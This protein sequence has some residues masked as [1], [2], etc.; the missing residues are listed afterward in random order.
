MA[1][2]RRG[3]HLSANLRTGAGL[4]S[5]GG[6]VSPR[7][8]STLHLVEL[9]VGAATAA[10]LES[11]VQRAIEV[12][13]DRTAE[14]GA[15][16]ASMHLVKGEARTIELVAARNLDE[17]VRRR[18]ARFSFDSES[19][20]AG[21]VRSGR[22]IWFERPE[23]VTPEFDIVR[24][25][26]EETEQGAVMSLPMHA[27]DGTL[28]AVLTIAL[29]EPHAFSPEEFAALQAIARAYGLALDAAQTR[30]SQHRELDRLEKL[31]EATLA[32]FGA[33]DLHV[34][35]QRIVE[36][37]RRVSGARFAALGIL[38]EDD[39][40][41]PFYPYVFS[42]DGENTWPLKKAVRPLPV[43]RAAQGAVCA[44]DLT[45]DDGA[46]SPPISVKNFLGSPVR[47]GERR[48]G[49]LYLVD[50]LGGTFSEDDATA[51]NLLAQHA[52]IA[53]EHARSREALVQAMR[54]KEQSEA[55]LRESEA[56]YRRL[57]ENAPDVVF[58]LELT[59][60]PH[61][62]FLSPAIEE[63][64]GQPP[65]VFYKDP[66]AL[67]R[68]VHPSDRA[69][70]DLMITAPERHGHG[71]ILRWIHRDGHLVWVEARF[72]ALRDESGRLLS[73][74]GI[75]RDVS[76]AKRAE[77]EVEILL[78][79]VRAKRAWLQTVIDR[80]PVGIVLL[81]DPEGR[82]ILVNREAQQLFGREIKPDGGVEQ[83]Q[84]Q[85]R[86]PEGRPIPTEEAL[87][88]RALHGEAATQEE[89]LALRPDGSEIP[90]LVSAT[91]IRDPEGQ[92]EGAVVIYRDISTLKELERMREEWTSI[93]AHDLRQP[94]N[95]I[96]LQASALVR[97]AKDPNVKARA[98][99]IL[100]S[101]RQL[102]RLISDLLEFSR[103][104]S[105]NLSIVHHPVDLAELARQVG[106][107]AL[108]AIPDRHFELVVE[109]DL[110]DVPCD[111]GRIEQVLTNLISNAVKYGY[112]NTPIRVV[113]DRESDRVV[114]SV[115]N[116]GQ[117][118][119]PE[120]LPRLFSR[121]H[122]AE[123]ARKSRIGGIGLGLYITR[124]L[125]DAH[126]GKVWAE[127]EP[128]GETRFSFSL[129]LR[130]TIELHPPM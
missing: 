116:R 101:S 30:A 87:Y 3:T 6:T 16:S 120:E 45:F 98:E 68:Q 52:A 59:P 67:A 97:H 118:I 74:E 15:S 55:K 130:P 66:E 127:S 100:A 17:G 93:I 37:A 109:G 105:R 39:P 20:V 32:I 86:W 85:L 62:S 92:V 129:P 49:E 1:D 71:V 84:K 94:V 114:V 8:T 27:R 51:V 31:R 123:N 88:W 7:L 103:I 35:L 104:E 122:R 34:V 12:M 53:V 124:G 102:A 110:P 46:V 115:I 128:G 18:I 29:P 72:V 33:T 48:I 126:G 79:R 23:D 57:V 5:D 76:A 73:V 80:S 78:D 26:L 107:R 13:L 113:I 89:R 58:R 40:N 90:V 61:F 112:P 44:L 25:I 28:I 22:A 21:V 65:E 36:E 56:R 42:G 117:G 9:A 111:A 64:L 119:P 47:L 96:S 41:A 14:L 106:F 108:S 70:L 77:R 24:Q 63:L 38:R 11:S 50:K 43:L 83:L 125:I 82:R 2:P 4:A 54:A 75:G 69:L 60:T 121:F 99:H 10:A 95:V 81:E 19:L 91:P